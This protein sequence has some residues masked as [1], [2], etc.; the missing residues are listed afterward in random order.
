MSDQ[1]VKIWVGIGASVLLGSTGAQAGTQHAWPEPQTAA[2][3]VLIASAAEQGGEGG[4]ESHDEQHGAGGEGGEASHGG[5]AGHGGEGGEGGEG[6]GA[7]S[8]FSS[9]GEGGEGGSGPSA[10]DSPG[11]YYTQLAL[12]LGHMEVGKALYESG[13]GD[14]GSAHMGHPA[15]ELLPLLREALEQRGLEAVE[16]QVEQLARNA[17]GNGD[18]TE[19][20]PTY[21]STRTAILSAMDHVSVEKRRD[22][23]FLARVAIAILHQARHE[24]EDSIED[25]AFVEAHEYQDSYGFVHVGRQILEENAT[26]FQ[27]A[28]ADAYAKLM[29]RYDAVTQAW[30]TATLP[31]QP[32]VSVSELYGRISSFEFTASQFF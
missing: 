8:V 32:M 20:Q 31:P 11:V 15:A 10:V 26:V 24:Y 27:R 18:W 17:T 1:R 12:M 3:P 30:P 4:E 23:G 9:G 7:M 6:G 21:R 13:H 14:V 29:E 5:E 19:V 22:P 2:S 16:K 25:G 28:D